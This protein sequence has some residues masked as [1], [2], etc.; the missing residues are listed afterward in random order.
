MIF[1]EKEIVLI[2]YVSQIL[3]IKV[4]YINFVHCEYNFITFLKKKSCEN[5]FY[6]K[7]EL[8]GMVG[9]T[10]GPCGALS[11]RSLDSF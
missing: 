6:P 9:L 5:I 8:A 3:Y 10:A 7:G 11:D 1:P 4:L 2:S